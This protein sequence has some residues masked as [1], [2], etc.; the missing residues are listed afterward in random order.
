MYILCFDGLFCQ[1][2]RHFDFGGEFGLMCYGWLIY[3]DQ[4]VI[5]RGRG[6]YVH[7]DVA[8]SSGAE[9]L[10]LI[11][12]LEALA[13][14]RLAKEPVLVVGDAK[15]VIDQ[16]QGINDVNSVRIR[17]LYKKARHLC[18]QIHSLYWL[19]VP[20]NQNKAADHLTRQALRHVR[21][22]RARIKS[23]WHEIKHSAGFHLIS[24]LMVC[25]RVG[26]AN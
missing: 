25:Q 20:R 3:K 14:L 21:H 16:M 23:G 19:W 8:S 17:R 11:E 22:A 5:A 15:A 4:Q 13:D 2:G 24:D 10:A 7:R 9:Y 18:Q 6:S 1:E 26:L 12:G